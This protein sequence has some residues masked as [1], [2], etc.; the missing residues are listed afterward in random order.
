MATLTGNKK[1]I[2]VF[3]SGRGTNLK[4]IYKF[5]QKKKSLFNIKLVIS[6]KKNVGGVIFSKK[7]KINTKVINYNNKN[8][9]EIKIL[10]ILNSNKIDIICLAGFMK[11]LSE[12]FIKKSKMKIL[13]IH[14]SL[15]PKYKGLNTHLRVIK[16]KEKFSGCTVHFVSKKLDSGKIII[17]RKVKINKNDTAKKLEK[18]ILKIENK[19]YSIAIMKVIKTNF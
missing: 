19:I 11:I 18:K 12:T 15:L 7:N 14:P 6:D 8:Y 9:A 5:S 16:N 10:K 2:A 13:N 3:I 4:S 17:Q 1:K